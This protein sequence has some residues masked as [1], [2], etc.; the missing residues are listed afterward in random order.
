MPFTHMHM[1]GR[2]GRR[3]GRQAGTY[4]HTHI[5]VHLEPAHGTKYHDGSVLDESRTNDNKL[6]LWPH[7]TEMLVSGQISLSSK[8]PFTGTT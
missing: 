2:A 3:A 8:F 7:H 6:C 1:G 5:H 4:T